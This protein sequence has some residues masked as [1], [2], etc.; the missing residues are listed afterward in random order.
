MRGRG[1]AVAVAVA[2]AMAMAMAVAG[3]VVGIA[4]WPDGRLAVAGGRVCRWWLGVR[5]SGWPGGRVAVAGGRG[6]WPWPGGGR[7]AGWMA[8]WP[9]PWRLFSIRLHTKQL[10]FSCISGNLPIHISANYTRR[11]GAKQQAC[12][13]KEE[14]VA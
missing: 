11:P 5:V 1:R 13:A 2:V 14:Q 10:V 3:P 4:G 6:W 7:V 12:A 9:R 8:G